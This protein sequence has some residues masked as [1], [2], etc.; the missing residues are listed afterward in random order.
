MTDQSASNATLPAG[1]NELLDLGTLLQLERVGWDA[2]C[3]PTGRTY[4][5]DLMT[6]DAVMVLVNGMVMDQPTIASTMNQ[7]PVW[8]RYDIRDA[9]V[10]PLGTD[11]A[12]LVYNATAMRGA[13]TF[14]ALMTS[15]YTLV[16]GRPRLKLYTQFFFFKQKTAYEI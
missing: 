11:S 4:Y 6:D 8:D 15:T 3:S 13:E 7:A 14:E 2:L 10:I 16:G 1:K 9:R 5:G 12:A